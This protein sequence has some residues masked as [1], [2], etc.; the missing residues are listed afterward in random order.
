MPVQHKPRFRCDSPSRALISV[1]I[2]CISPEKAYSI[3][4]LAPRH[5]LFLSQSGHMRHPEPSSDGPSWQL[6]SQLS[7]CWAD[8]SREHMLGF[9]LGNQRTVS[10]GPDSRQG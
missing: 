2:F 7:G 4:L 3:S 1:L 10:S 8:S 5:G 9:P 6:C